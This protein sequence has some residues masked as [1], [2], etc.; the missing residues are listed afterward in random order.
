MAVR[1][2]VNAILLLVILSRCA[3]AM[4]GSVG[5]HLVVGIRLDEEVRVSKRENNV[6]NPKFYTF[7]K[8]C[9]ESYISPTPLGVDRPQCPMAWAMMT[10]WQG[11]PKSAMA[12]GGLTM[13]R[14]QPKDRL[15]R[16]THGDRV[17]SEVEKPTSKVNVER[18]RWHDRPE[19]VLN[20]DNLDLSARSMGQVGAA[21]GAICRVR[22]QWLASGASLVT[23]SL[24]EWS[25]VRSMR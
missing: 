6:N 1:A 17:T 19:L 4:R 9:T 12:T 14:W 10:G 13:A 7:T 15:V 20:L 22:N 24:G 3:C 25:P 21:M 18:L 5:S 8:N 23:S 11:S 16:M 2:R